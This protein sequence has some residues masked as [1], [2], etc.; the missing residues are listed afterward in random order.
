MRFPA[1]E[2]KNL[3]SS[4][5]DSFFPVVIHDVIYVC[6]LNTNFSVVCTISA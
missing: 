5:I 3:L 6:L 4:L 2:G 1:R